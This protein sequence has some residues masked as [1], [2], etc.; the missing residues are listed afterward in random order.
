MFFF[1]AIFGNFA[2]LVNYLPNLIAIAEA[3]G[4]DACLIDGLNQNQYRS[5]RTREDKK[6]KKTN[7]CN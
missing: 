7:S 5:T 1:L 3:T 6:M 4:Y 2:I